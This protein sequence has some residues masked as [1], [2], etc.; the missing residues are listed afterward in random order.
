MSRLVWSGASTAGVAADAAATVIVPFASVYQGG[1]LYRVRYIEPVRTGSTAG[2]V[3]EVTAVQPEGQAALAGIAGFMVSGAP[4]H[5][6]DVDLCGWAGDSLTV[7][8]VN[9]S[10]AVAALA[11]NIALEDMGPDTS[12]PQP[13]GMEG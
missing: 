8:I 7:S 9:R 1:R 13:I 11:V 12:Y 6:V 3:I 10:G 2:G 4:P 5:A